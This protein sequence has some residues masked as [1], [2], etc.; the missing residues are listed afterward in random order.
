M[1]PARARRRLGPESRA[2]VPRRVSSRRAAKQRILVVGDGAQTEPNYFRRLRDEQ[3]VRDRYA[4]V[5]RGA[6]ARTP[7]NAVKTALNEIEKDRQRGQRFDRVW[8]VLDVETAGEN[9]G[10][11]DAIALARQHRIDVALSNPS[12]EVWL[13]AHFERTSASF[14]GCQEVIARLNKHWRIV[15]KADYQKNDDRI[16]QRIACR[17]QTAVSN[18]R[19]VREYDFR[20]ENDTRNCNSSTEV[21]QLVQFLLG[22]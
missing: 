21:Y 17:T 2:G 4:V 7:H 15:S 12:F 9:P 18:A 3:V 14:R 5:V 8:C 16:Y 6:K 22:T 1:R 11:E 13:L 20:H 19:Q 10:L